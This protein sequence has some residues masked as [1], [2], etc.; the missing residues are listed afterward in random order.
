M[1]TEF[2]SIPGL[3]S[4]DAVTPSLPSSEQPK[5]SPDIARCPLSG[6]ITLAENL[7]GGHFPPP[8]DI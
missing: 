8:L 4:L 5:M 7:V 3:Y 6:E 1:G 2:S